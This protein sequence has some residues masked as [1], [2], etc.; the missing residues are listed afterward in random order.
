MSVVTQFKA[1]TPENTGKAFVDYQR[2]F[3]INVGDLDSGAY[4]IPIRSGQTVLRARALITTAWDGS[5]TIDIGDGTTAGLFM[6]NTAIT[7]A[8]RGSLGL[9]TAGKH[10]TSDGVVKVTVGGS[11]TAGQVVVTLDFDGY[12]LGAE[13][14]EIA[15][16]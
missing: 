12:D 5:A 3:V 7:E 14:G 6:A 10:Y 2:R 4:Y 16:F 11:P 13:R 15:N 9:G 1:T 8:T